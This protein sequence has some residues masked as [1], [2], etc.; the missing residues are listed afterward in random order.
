[1]FW[2]PLSRNLR[3]TAVETRHQ[4]YRCWRRFEGITGNVYV[5]ATFVDEF[6]RRQRI[7]C[8]RN[9]FPLSG[10]IKKQGCCQK[11]LTA[12]TPQRIQLFNKRTPATRYSL[13]AGHIHRSG[14]KINLVSSENCIFF[15][16]RRR[17]DID[18]ESH[19][20]N[21][22]ILHETKLSF[23]INLSVSSIQKRNIQEWKSILAE[24]VDEMWAK[25]GRNTI[26][27]KNHL[28]NR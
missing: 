3:P 11:H 18:Y 27:T 7:N 12:F 6:W 20:S 1:M 16:Q 13:P 24:G 14:R 19:H 4:C 5:R 17:I 15:S 23:W 26:R 21:S 10:R 28:R 8:S 2:R 9:I 25:R 22:A